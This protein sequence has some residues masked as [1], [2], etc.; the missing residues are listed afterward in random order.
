M[1]RAR[2]NDLYHVIECTNGRGVNQLVKSLGITI[3]HSISMY[4]KRVSLE[5]GSARIV[6][7]FLSVAEPL[8]KGALVPA[9]FFCHVQRRIRPFNHIFQIPF[10]LIA[11]KATCHSD[12]YGNASAFFL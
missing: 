5:P 6:I 8:F 2:Y 11:N 9:S 7:V 10:T 1:V 3:K 12:A 4:N